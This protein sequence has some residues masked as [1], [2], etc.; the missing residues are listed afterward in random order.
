VRGEGEAY[1]A[2]PERGAPAAPQNGYAAQ[3]GP[4]RDHTTQLAAAWRLRTLAN[5][6]EI[7]PD[8]LM[9]TAPQE[10]RVLLE[11]IDAFSESDHGPVWLKAFEAG[12]QEQLISKLRS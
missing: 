6:L 9:E 5:A 1:R 12:Y 8:V 10:L 2:W 3:F 4:R 11:W 7:A